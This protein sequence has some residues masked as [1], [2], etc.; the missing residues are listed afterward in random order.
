M[1]SVIQ[2]FTRTGAAG[3]AARR[4]GRR[5]RR[6][7]RHGAR[8]SG[9]VR[10]TAGE[11]TTRSAPRASRPTTRVPNNEFRQHDAVGIGGVA[12]STTA[13]RCAASSVRSSATSGMP[14]Q[15][16]FGRPD[17]RR[18]LRSPRRRRRRHASTQTITSTLRQ[19]RDLRTARHA[20]DVHQPDPRSAL[21]AGVRGT[22]GAVRVLRLPLR[23]P[24]R[25]SSSLRELSGRLALPIA[26]GGGGHTHRRRSPSTG[27]ANG[28]LL[29]RSAGDD[30]ERASRNNV[31]ITLQHQ[32]L[33]SR[34]VRDGGRAV[35]A[36]R[37]LRHRRRSARLD[38]LCRA[39]RE[40]RARR[41]RR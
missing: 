14:G 13:R 7:L 10:G 19:Q 27:K 6:Q 40:R 28:Q 1:A 20:S 17:S 2:L 38:R 18:L 12:L 37:Q 24:H 39:P 33:W 32:A 26:D 34:V 4:L 23:Q 3:H 25:P 21:H 29:T 5:G 35:R 22:H 15:T 9:G 11:A 8:L 31:G 41:T 16:A 30:D 36:Q